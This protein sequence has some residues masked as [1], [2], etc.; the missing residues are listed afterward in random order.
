MVMSLWPRFFGPSCPFS[1]TGCRANWLGGSDS[2]VWCLSAAAAADVELPDV[3][4]GGPPAYERATECVLLASAP[5]PSRPPRSTAAEVA[6]TVA[7]RSRRAAVVPA[8]APA[9]VDGVGERRLG[10]RE[11]LVVRRAAGTVVAGVSRAR[12]GAATMV[13]GGPHHGS[14]IRLEAGRVVIAGVGR[15]RQRHRVKLLRQDVIFLHQFIQHN[16]GT[17]EANSRR[18]ASHDTDRT[19][20]SGLMWRCELSQPDRQ[21]GAFCV[22]SGSETVCRAAQCDRRTHSDAERTS[23]AVNSHRHT[24]QERPSRLPSR[25]T[26]HTQRRC[27]PRKIYTCCGLLHMTKPK[28]LH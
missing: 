6:E 28:L 14:S 27:K 22:W 12:V 2:E 11:R 16:N 15:W 26:A 20:L 18:H 19:V 21:T 10:A 23:R 8:G 25:P 4:S 3:D 13:T 7:E 24:R 1:L 17:V 5:A 9:A